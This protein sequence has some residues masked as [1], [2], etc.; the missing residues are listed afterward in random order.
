M[1]CLCELLRCCDAQIDN[2][3]NQRLKMIDKCDNEMLDFVIKEII[4]TFLFIYD[5]IIKNFKSYN[6]VLKILNYFYRITDHDCFNDDKFTWWNGIIDS[7]SFFS[8]LHIPAMRIHRYF[9]EGN[10]RCFDLTFDNKRRSRFCLYL[11]W[12]R[13]M[14]HYEWFRVI[15]MTLMILIEL[16]NWE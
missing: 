1:N 3:C 14:D 2:V 9:L 4:K 11:F 12:F 5:I 16:L 15:R 7:L 10:S 13:C 8:K 6:Q